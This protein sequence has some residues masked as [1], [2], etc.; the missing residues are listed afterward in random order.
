MTI[1]GRHETKAN[2]PANA[3][4][5]AH[6]VS[7]DD[8]RGDYCESGEEND[9]HQTRRVKAIRDK[10]NVGVTKGKADSGAVLNPLHDVVSSFLTVR[11]SK[12]CM[13]VDARSTLNDD[14]RRAK[15]EALLAA[16][17]AD[18][19][20][21]ALSG[22]ATPQAVYDRL[23]REPDRHVPRPDVEKV[24]TSFD[25]PG[26][27]E[28]DYVRCGHALRRVL[29]EKDDRARLQAAREQEE[30]CKG[31]RDVPT[32]NGTPILE[33]IVGEYN[34]IPQMFQN[35]R[36]FVSMCVQ[37]QYMDDL[38]DF[39]APCVRVD[40]YAGM[41]PAALDN[42]RHF[43]TRCL[44]HP[45]LDVYAQPSTRIDTYSFISCTTRSN[46]PD[47]VPNSFESSFV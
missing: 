27:H 1:E 9:A 20:K 23:Q 22:G 29:D 15:D 18:A 42:V 39:F 26:R 44:D 38:I 11:D 30:A 34:N 32:P 16:T 28:F 41:D 45:S 6:V 25:V 31:L 43:P 5:E 13:S 19:A 36:Q 37:R 35:R 8:V 33:T 47:L 7:A 40:L 17:T 24:L 46:P 21:E 2:P 10:V 3:Q 14:E 12:P 4:A